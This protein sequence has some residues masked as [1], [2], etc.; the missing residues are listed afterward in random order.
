MLLLSL[1]L[2]GTVAIVAP[3]FAVA[4]PFTVAIVAVTARRARPEVVRLVFCLDVRCSSPD[5][6]TLPL[7]RLSLG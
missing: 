7:P 3:E 1:L 6:I 4:L 2:G 5:P